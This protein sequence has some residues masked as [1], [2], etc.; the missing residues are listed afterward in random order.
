MLSHLTY[1]GLKKILFAQ[2]LLNLIKQLIIL[3]NLTGCQFR[4]AP[5]HRILFG[6]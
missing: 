1:I 3:E 4:S 5:L 2:L 6:T